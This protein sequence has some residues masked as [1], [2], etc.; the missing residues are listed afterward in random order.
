MTVPMFV[1]FFGYVF[2]T[3]YRQQSKH[4]LINDEF[5]VIKAFKTDIQMT[6]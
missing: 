2:M 4:Y 6:K 5:R 1:T 3:I